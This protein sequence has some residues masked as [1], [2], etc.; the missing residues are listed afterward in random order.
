MIFGYSDGC[1]AVRIRL[2]WYGTRRRGTP[3]TSA[4]TAVSRRIIQVF[5]SATAGS[6]L[7]LELHAI[8]LPPPSMDPRHPT[9][10]WM[11]ATDT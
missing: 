10:A 5:S 11:A 6:V 4:G 1:A 9:R 7:F 8:I 3:G 2:V